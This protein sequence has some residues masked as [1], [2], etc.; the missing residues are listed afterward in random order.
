MEKLNDGIHHCDGCELF[1]C[2]AQEEVSII[3]I[4]GACPVPCCRMVLVP[5][6]PCEDRSYENRDVGSLKMG[7]DGWCQY[8]KE[9]IGCTIYN[10]RPI[11]CRVASCRFIRE[12]KIPKEIIDFMNLKEGENCQNYQSH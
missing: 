3:D 12:G 9:E 11:A 6:V 4:C 2:S 7:N 1:P 8:F 10:V 5:L